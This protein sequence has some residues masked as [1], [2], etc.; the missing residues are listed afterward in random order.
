MLLLHVYGLYATQK[1]K[2]KKNNKNKKIKRYHES[3]DA[4]QGSGLTRFLCFWG[5][6]PYV[7]E[8]PIIISFENMF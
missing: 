3:G 4:L 8:G 6:L 2:E 7:K 5:P 1:Y